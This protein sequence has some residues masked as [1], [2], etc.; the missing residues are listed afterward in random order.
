MTRAKASQLR[1]VL[2]HRVSSR[3]QDP[4]LARHELRVA[5][6]ARSMKVVGQIEETG[7]G[8][9]NDRP[10]LQQVMDA[11]RRGQIRART[12]PGARAL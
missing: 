3:D 8:A 10:G 1:A 2:Y 7:S 12:R 11:A 6:R 9:R 4:K 5:A